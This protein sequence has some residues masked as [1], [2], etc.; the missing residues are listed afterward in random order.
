MPGLGKNKTGR[1]PLLLIIILLSLFFRF[2][3]LAEFFP[4]GMDQEYEL[5]LVKNIT[6]GVHIPLIGVNAGDTGIYLGPIFI[7]LSVIPYLLFWGNPLGFAFTASATGVLTTIVLFYVVREMFS[8]KAAYFSSFIYSV[9]FLASFYDRNYW[10]PS[11]VPLLSLLIGFTIY[12]INLK[13]YKYLYYLALFFGL[14]LHT[15]LS[16]LIFTPLIFWVL[17]KHFRHMGIKIFAYSLGIFLLLQLP[18]IIFEFRHNYTNTKAVIS[19]LSGSKVNELTKSGPVNNGM[20]FINYL[21]RFIWVPP[22]PDLFVEKGLCTEL[23]AYKKNAYPEIIGMIIIFLIYFIYFHK[24]LNNGKHSMSSRIVISIF[25]L[26]LVTIF[27]YNRDFQEYNLQ[28]LT[29]YLAIILGV[30]AGII[31]QKKEGQSL[32]LLFFILYLIV[33]MFTLLTA[34]NSYS[35]QK[36]KEIINFSKKYTKNS[37]YDLEA[38]GDCPRFAGWYYMFEYYSGRPASSYMDSYFNK[39]NLEAVTDTPSENIVLLSMIDPRSTQKSIETWQEEKLNYIS[40]YNITVQ[41]L[42]ENIHVFILKPKK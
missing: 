5:F 1:F 7:Y 2:Y 20:T 33:N 13:K 24:I 36:K 34:T 14:T 40:R 8:Q 29:P 39:M 22:F 4:F 19:M 27:I 15:N 23:S 30:L 21:G 6:H 9:S 11:A 41:K 12:Q 38:I 31:W 37:S 10:N 3:K 32:V 25:I 16:L 18:L 35:Y 26:S 17:I 42:I 28:F